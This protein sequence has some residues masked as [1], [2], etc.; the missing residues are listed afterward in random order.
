M[1]TTCKYVGMMYIDLIWHVV[2]KLSNIKKSK[3]LLY[4]VVAVKH[5]CQNI[6][7]QLSG[8]Q[9]KLQQLENKLTL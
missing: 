3:A 1:T 6:E 7:K 2:I 8:L 9:N 4:N 5:Q